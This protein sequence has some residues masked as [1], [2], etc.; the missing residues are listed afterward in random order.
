MNT[1][2]ILAQITHQL[3]VA[4]MVHFLATSITKD[5]SDDPEG[6]LEAV[7]EMLAAKPHSGGLG[8][9]QF[10]TRCKAIAA[11]ES[12]VG[13]THT[14]QVAAVTL[15]GP[16]DEHVM[17]RVDMPDFLA[18]ALAATYARMK[19]EGAEISLESML[20]AVTANQ[21]TPTYGERIH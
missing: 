11:C 18:D 9:G 15:H 2:R 12:A 1:A 3:R 16:D 6:A 5:A 4:E 17:K 13:V 10:I 19:S 8:P 21:T 20:D 14:G 7:T